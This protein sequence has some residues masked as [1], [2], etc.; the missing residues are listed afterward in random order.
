MKNRN[1]TNLE[2][3]RQERSALKMAYLQQEQVLKLDVNTFIHQF[4]LGNLIKKYATPSTL[5]KLDEQ[6]HLSSKILAVALPMLMNS[7]LFK[8]SGFI[9]KTIAALVSGKIGKS[10]DAES[11]SGIFNMFKNWIS[12][13][14]VNKTEPN[15]KDYGI[16]PDSETF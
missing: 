2:E 6:T 10:L 13:K 14:K 4:T 9:T 3:L 12:G 8:N 5:Y 1:I 7:V 15:F 11:L 16:P